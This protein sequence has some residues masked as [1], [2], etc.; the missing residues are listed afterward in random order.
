M[1]KR[2]RVLEEQR[3]DGDTWWF[4]QVRRWGHWWEIG[5]CFTL[6]A[7]HSVIAG[8]RKLRPLRKI[9]HKA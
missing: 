3:P 8:D 9:I 7:A 5:Q 4:P 2:Y 1:R 6:E